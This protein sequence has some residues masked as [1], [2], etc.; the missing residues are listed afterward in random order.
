M[1]NHS[2]VLQLKITGWFYNEK[3][4]FGSTMKNPKLSEL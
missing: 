3:S 4:Q 1:K 2:L